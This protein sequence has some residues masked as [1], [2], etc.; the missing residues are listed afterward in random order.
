MRSLLL[1]FLVAA[2]TASAAVSTQ[3]RLERLVECHNLAFS[4]ESCQAKELERRCRVRCGE[5]LPS[6]LASL[7]SRYTIPLD[8][9]DDVS[10]KTLLML[11]PMLAPSL[12]YK[13][14]DTAQAL[15]RRVGGRVALHSLLEFGFERRHLVRSHRNL[16][17]PAMPNFS[18]FDVAMSAMLKSGAV[19]RVADGVGGCSLVDIVLRKQ[20]R[21][22]FDREH[23]SQTLAPLAKA[24]LNLTQCLNRVEPDYWGTNTV[25]TLVYAGATPPRGLLLKLV[26]EH[27][28][29]SL[30]RLSDAHELVAPAV[31]KN[32]DCLEP[33]GAVSREAI[34]LL[35]TRYT[36]NVVAKRYDISERIE[37]VYKAVEN[38]DRISLFLML[39]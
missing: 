27:A 14:S 34:S 15:N 26:D 7:V 37:A 6:D 1:S 18:Q 5:E 9:L 4:A 30:S 35:D 39:V 24:G 29:N 16:A 31:D 10:G 25:R 36:M 12:L 33:S 20:P 22:S 3:K 2:A 17:N 23:I 38:D 11:A 32:G 13:A 28:S 8:S 19:P 21:C